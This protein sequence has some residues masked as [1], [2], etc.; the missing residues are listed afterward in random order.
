MILLYV[1]FFSVLYIRDFIITQYQNL[2]L[3]NNSISMWR[4]TIRYV[5]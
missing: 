1:L 4:D 3:R 5:N 2:V